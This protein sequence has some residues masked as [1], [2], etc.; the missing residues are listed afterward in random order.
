MTLEQAVA[1]ALE[2]APEAT[3]PAGDAVV[4]HGW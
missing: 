1:Y 4:V 2:D 3:A